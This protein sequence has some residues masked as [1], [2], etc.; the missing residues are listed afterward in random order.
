MFDE[1]R[2]ENAV[3]LLD[4]ADSFLTDRKHALH[5]W[6]VTQTNELLTQLERFR[7]AF[8]ATTNAFDVLDAASIRRFDLK[9]RFDV[10]TLTQRVRLF[11]QVL[12]QFG[13]PDPMAPVLDEQDIVSSLATLTQ[14]T[15]GDVAVVVKRLRAT[16]QGIG[17]VA[18]LN[19]LRDECRH[20]NKQ[21]APIGFHS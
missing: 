7:G 10:L 12:H 13:D 3:L 1:A 21:H 9:V 16:G 6:E 11:N 17:R 14:L 5:S 19:G 20:K 8:I 4:E 18:L 2:D 15:T